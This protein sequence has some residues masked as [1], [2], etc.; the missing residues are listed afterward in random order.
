MDPVVSIRNA[1]FCEACFLDGVVHRFRSS[2]L[3]SKAVPNHSKALVAVSGGPCSSALLQMSAEFSNPEHPKR[4]FSSLHVCHVDQ[5]ILLKQNWNE[6][7]KDMAQQYQLESSIVSLSSLFNS[8]QELAKLFDT[9]L[10]N[11][12]ELLH[13]LTMECLKREAIRYGCESILLGDSATWMAIKVIANTSKG[14]GISLA[15]DISF[16]TK[17][18]DVIWLRPM[19]DILAKEIELFN[20][21]KQIPSVPHTT[22]TTGMATKSSINKATT[23][24]ILQLEEDFPAT[25]STVIRTAYKLA[26]KAS[27]HFTCFICQG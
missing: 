25:V 13:Y 8:E 22:L 27:S 19:R 3:K 2:L 24:F 9:N 4:K 15:E 6:Q 16:Q 21:F 7:V 11:Q 23:D 10:T 14:R 26:P 18:Q 20:N 5:S 12:E 17:R 1:S